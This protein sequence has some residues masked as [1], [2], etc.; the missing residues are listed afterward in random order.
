MEQTTRKVDD[1]PLIRAAL[2]AAS[3]GSAWRVLIARLFEK[4][5]TNAD[6]H[7]IG[8]CGG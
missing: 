7:G 5:A 3:T 6:E 1:M 8:T 4:A 2:R